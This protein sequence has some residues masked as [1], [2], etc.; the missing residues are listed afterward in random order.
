M[1]RW[2]LIDEG[3]ADLGRH[4]SFAGGAPMNTFAHLRR[5]D[6]LH[7]SDGS[8]GVGN[9]SVTRHAD[10]L[11]LNGQPDLLSS[12]Q[13]IRMVNQTWEE[14]LARRT[15][16]ET[17]APDHLETRIKVARAFSKLVMALYAG[18]LRDLCGPHVCLGRWLA[19]LE[20]RILFHELAKWVRLVEPAGEHRYLRSNFVGGIKELPVTMIR[21]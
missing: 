3:Y 7:W 21:M 19:R 16:Q 9:W 17:D 10:I 6:P 14:Y 1:K 2:T 11:A 13:G 12:A 4:D 20:V 5:G 18:V 15:F 8:G